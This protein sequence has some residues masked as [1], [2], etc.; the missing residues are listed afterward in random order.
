MKNVIR[1]GDMTSHGGAV[2]TTSAPHYIVEGKPVACVGDK[3]TCPIPG[4]GAGQ[5]ME[6]DGSHVVNGKAVSFHGH[7]T[8][9]GATLITS[10]SDYGRS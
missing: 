7:K 10:T 8:S 1:L 4:H 6:G 9:C 2:I 5:I 3:C